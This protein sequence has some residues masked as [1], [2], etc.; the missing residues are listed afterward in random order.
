MNGK[1][2]LV[3]RVTE[4]HTATAAGVLVGLVQWALATYVFHGSEPQPAA[5][6]GAHRWRY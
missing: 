5:I 6:A 4:T 3:R 1:T 2:A